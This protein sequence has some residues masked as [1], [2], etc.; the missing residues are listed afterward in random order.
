MRCKKHFPDL[1]SSVGVC[2]SCLRERLQPILEAQAQ[3]QARAQPSR[4]SVSETSLQSSQPD[5]PRSV[6]P[7]VSRRKSGDRRRENL[8]QSTPQVD[9]GYTTAH[10][11]GRESSKKMIKRFWLLSTLFRSRTNKK[12]NSS[13]GSCEPSSSASPPSLTWLSAVVN[14]RRQN[15]RVSDQRKRRQL[16]RGMSP[17]DNFERDRSDLENS[18]ESSPQQKSTA[19]TSRRSR[20][21]YAGKSLTSM[22]FCLSPLVRASPN[23]QWNSHKG[24]AQDLGVGGVHHISSAATFCANRSRK[25]VDLGRVSHKR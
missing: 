7:Y 17:V 22:A 1:T 23:R 9:Q 21:G 4:S 16:D 13:H 15:N 19:I 24:L 10:D 12:E 2:A 3:A 25:L 8:F 5:F 6:S 11:G 18:S 14:P 20:L